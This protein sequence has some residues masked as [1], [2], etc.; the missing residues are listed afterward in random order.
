VEMS[1]SRIKKKVYE[2]LSKAANAHR[3]SNNSDQKELHF[4]F[5]RRPT[6]FLPSENGSTVGVIQLEK[7]FLKG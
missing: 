4:V 6:R 7:T 2:L 5:F 1:S 3:H